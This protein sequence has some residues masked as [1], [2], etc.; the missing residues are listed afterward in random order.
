HRIIAQTSPGAH[1]DHENHNGLDN[2]KTNLRQCTFR[3][4]QYNRLPT[5][6]CRSQYRGVCWGRIGWVARIKHNSRS[7]WLGS[8]TSEVGAAKAYNRK[9]QELFGEFAYLNPIQW[10]MVRREVYH[11]LSAQKARNDKW[12]RVC[13]FLPAP[14]SCNGSRVFFHVPATPVTCCG[15]TAWDWISI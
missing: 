14:D 1:T 7:I 13:N 4:N 2:R 5:D 3:E 8:H 12:N 10:W 6:N 9:A 15:V 11:G